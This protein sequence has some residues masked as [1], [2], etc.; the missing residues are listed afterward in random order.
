M[1]GRWHQGMDKWLHINQ[2]VREKR[3]AVL[4][5]QETHLTK[6][7]EDNLNEIFQTNLRIISSI[8]PERPNVA[9]VAIVLNKKLTAS[10][11]IITHEIK[12]G[13]ALLVTIP[14]QKETLSILAVYAPNDPLDS[15]NFWEEIRTKLNNLPQPD[16]MM[17]DFN[18]VEDALD[19]LPPRKDPVHAVES[20][21]R[22]KFSLDLRDGWR[23][24]NPDSSAFS[25]AQSAAQDIL[26]FSKEWNIGPPGMTTDH[27]LISARISNKR[28]PYVGRGHWT[29]PLFILKD[30]QVH[31]D[32]IAL[33]KEMHRSIERSKQLRT[34]SKNPQIALKEFKDNAIALCRKA[35]KK[36]IPKI[37]R[38]INTL[39]TDLKATLNEIDL[40]EGEKR[41]AQYLKR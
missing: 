14:W 19:R 15:H 10:K 9:G 30:K 17:G 20:L 8:D 31:D 33:G 39:K 1:R 23:S 27:Q 40:P 13:R 12:P 24:E 35:A 21:L 11:D 16:I 34:A 41:L 22:L 5:V 25:F 4:A 2:I 32:L 29:L 18:I 36:S 26:P 37:Q 3:I 28:M 7:E 38:S 6:N